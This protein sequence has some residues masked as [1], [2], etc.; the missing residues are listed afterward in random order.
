ME[1]KVE[2]RIT[3]KTKPRLFRVVFRLKFD[4]DKEEEKVSFCNFRFGILKIF[5]CGIH[6]QHLN[7][8]SVK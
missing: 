4:A 1:W 7:E 2:L 8:K 5:L 6:I 3:G